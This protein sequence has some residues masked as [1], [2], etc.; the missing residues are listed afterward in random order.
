MNLDVRTSVVATS[1]VLL[2]IV[3][4]R[5]VSRRAYSSVPGFWAWTLADA[6]LALGIGSVAVRNVLLPEAPSI[7]IVCVLS[8]VGFEV[9]YLGVRQF[10]GVPPQRWSSLLPLV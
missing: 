2:L 6:A 4:S 3:A 8:I 10:L 7:A 9:R 1:L 5:I